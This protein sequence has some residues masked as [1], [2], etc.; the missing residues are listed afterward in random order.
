MNRS[1][2]SSSCFPL[3]VSLQRCPP[4]ITGVSPG[5]QLP[6]HRSSCATWPP[7]SPARRSPNLAG[8]SRG[9]VAPLPA[10][11]ATCAVDHQQL[12]AAHLRTSFWLWNA[13]SELL[14]SSIPSRAPAFLFFFLLRSTT[15]PELLC[16]PPSTA[17]ATP[18]L[19]FHAPLAPLHLTTPFWPA[20]LPSP[21]RAQPRTPHRRFHS[22]PPSCF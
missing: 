5:C 11:A 18:P 10:R 6:P 14:P 1:S 8:S 16:P 3:S 2:F 19:Q 7:S 15:S 17:S 13:P 21:A 22:P 12:L 4:S 20:L 9:H